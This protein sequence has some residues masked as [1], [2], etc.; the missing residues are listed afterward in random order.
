VYRCLFL[1][2]GVLISTWQ[3]LQQYIEVY[4]WRQYCDI[5]F[6]CE[7]IFRNDHAFYL[8][9]CNSVAPSVMECRE[10]IADCSLFRENNLRFQFCTG[11]LKVKVKVTLRPTVS[12]VSMSGCL[13]HSGTCDQIIPPASKSLSCLYEAPSLTRG[14]VCSLQC[15]HSLVRVTQNPQ[16]YF[17]VSPDNSRSRK[18]LPNYLPTRFLV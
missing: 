13:A 3:E 14:R 1:I 6:R 7:V 17:T 12:Q 10:E 18:H 5:A 8:C 9:V 11:V 4:R 15:N 2:Q 16:P